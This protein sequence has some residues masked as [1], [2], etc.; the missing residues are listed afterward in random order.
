MGLKKDSI[1]EIVLDRF[2]DINSELVGRF[3]VMDMDGS[4]GLYLIRQL[5]VWQQP[6]EPPFEEPEDEPNSEES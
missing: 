5:E 1:I 4:R 2:H 3:K 6:I